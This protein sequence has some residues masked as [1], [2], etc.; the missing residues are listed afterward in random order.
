MVRV[1]FAGLV[2]FLNIFIGCM[3]L[4][5]PIVARYC[6]LRS[7]G[8]LMR[9][10]RGYRDSCDVL[11]ICPSA[12]KYDCSTIVCAE[13]KEHY[14]LCGRAL[15][16]CA[17]KGHKECFQ[18][19]W[20]LHAEVRNAYMFDCDERSVDKLMY[21]Y[22]TYYGTQ[23]RAEKSFNKIAACVFKYYDADGLKTIFQGREL[24]IPHKSAAS[25]LKD[26]CYM[27]DVDLIFKYCVSYGHQFDE[28]TLKWVI[29][30]GTSSAVR[31]LIENGS[32]RVDD[33]GKD[34]K[35]SVH[36]AALYNKCDSMKVLLEHGFRVNAT[37]NHGKTPLHYAAAS[38]NIEATRLLLENGSNVYIVDHDGKMARDCIPF[39]KTKL[40]G[41]LGEDVSYRKHRNKVVRDLLEECMKI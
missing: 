31:A 20:Q 14:Y 32:L 1:F 29:K 19:W 15:A 16:Y 37:D 3:D 35:T 4:G 28:K 5:M 2:L 10:N 24:Y 13:L 22:N 39:G 6:D 23:E 40:L 7:L 12:R 8:C 38:S 33:V 17:K 27:G 36:L 21:W 11:K 25:V 18:H 34:N 30:Y 9:T 26:I 41:W